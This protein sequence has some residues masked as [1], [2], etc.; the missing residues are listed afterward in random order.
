MKIYNYIILLVV[1]FLIFSFFYAADFVMVMKSLQKIGFR[2]FI[3]ILI[4]FFAALLSTLGWKYCMAEDGKKIPLSK[5]FIARHIGE[6]FAVINPTSVVAGDALKVYLLRKEGVSKKSLAASVLI[7]RLLKI[8]SQL[9]IFAVI[10]FYI[11]NQKLNVKFKFDN[12]I[13]YILAIPVAIFIV[14]NLVIRLTFL[15]K[16][17]VKSRIGNHIV[18]RVKFLSN[19]LKLVKEE[20]VIQFSQNKKGLIISF[21]LFFIHWLLGPLECF[22]IMKFMNIDITAMQSLLMDHGIVVIKSLGS[23]I[24]G[25]I[26]VEELGNKLVLSLIG[27]F[28]AQ[29]WLTFSVLRR[30]RQLFWII[31]ALIMYLFSVTLQKDSFEGNAALEEK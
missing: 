22:F 24:P 15:Q 8:L 4:T 14:Y 6:M 1:L 5:L 11:L 30:T 2:F 13:F 17:L 7:S 19:K 16:Y 21:F 31:V 25:Q 12:L 20:V 10:I 28:A 9:V 18:V 29:T 23:F 26:G 3:L 27:V